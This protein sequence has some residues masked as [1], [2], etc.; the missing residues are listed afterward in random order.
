MTTILTDHGDV[1]VAATNGLCLS[2][3]DTERAT[4]WILK[5]EGLCRDALSRSMAILKR[6]WGEALV[7]K[8]G[9]GFFLFLLALPGIA[10]IVGGALLLQTNVPLGIAVLAAGGVYLLIDLAVSAALNS[11]FVSALY[12]YAAQNEV[13]VGFDGDMM[14]HAVRTA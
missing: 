9:L 12:R 11:I 10:L 7:G 8:M 6:T 1:T 14:R 3:A 4:Q 13:P 5:P 2:P